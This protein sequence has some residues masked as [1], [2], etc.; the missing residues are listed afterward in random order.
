VSVQVNLLVS[1]RK[2]LTTKSNLLQIKYK[3]RTLR[4]IEGFFV[5]RFDRLST[6]LSSAIKLSK[7]KGMYNCS[8]LDYDVMAA[9]QSFPDDY[10]NRMVFSFAPKKLLGA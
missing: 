6:Q 5:L 2:S 4:E 3:L 10:K 8:T 9:Y 7:E 1:V